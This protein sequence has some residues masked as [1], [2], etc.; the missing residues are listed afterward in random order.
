VTAGWLALWYGDGP[1]GPQSW[2]ARSPSS[3]N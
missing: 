2:G 1:S 3:V